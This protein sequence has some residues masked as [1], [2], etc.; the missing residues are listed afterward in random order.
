MPG[1]EAA[2]HLV[3]CTGRAVRPIARFSCTVAHK[4]MKFTMK[5]I[6]GLIM[7]GTTYI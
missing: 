6:Q 5:E 2:I 1:F 3:A 4:E 7:R